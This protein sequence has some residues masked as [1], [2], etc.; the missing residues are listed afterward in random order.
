MRRT[1]TSENGAANAHPE[2]GLMQ[3][4]RFGDEEHVERVLKDLSTLGV[5]HLRTGISWADWYRPQG[6]AWYDWLL[7]RLAE[8]VNV[9]PCVTYTPPSLGVVPRS[10]APPRNPKL[11]AD[12]LDVLVTRSGDC[13]DTVELWNEPNNINNWDWRLDPDWAIFY[14]MIGGAAHWMKQRGKR[15]VLGGV[16]P[17]NFN[18]LRLLCEKKVLQNID[19]VGLCGLPGTWEHDTGGDWTAQIRSLHDRLKGLG[20]ERPLWITGTGYSTWRNDEH[21]QLLE[22]LK[23]VEAP[24][25]RVYW[26]S[27]DDLDPDW[28]FEEGFLQDERNYHFGL[29]RNDGTAKLLY[30]V[31]ASGGL[32]AIRSFAGLVN[33]VGRENSGHRRNSISPIRQRTRFRSVPSR[34]SSKPIV[35][36][37][38]AG[39]IGTNVAAKLAEDGHK[40]ILY[41][42]LSRPGVERN[43]RWLLDEFGE[44]IEVHVADVRD[45]YSLRRSVASAQ[46]IFHFAAQVAVTTSLVDPINDFTINGR[47]TLNVLE[48]CRSLKSPPPLLFTST[49]KVYGN[50]EDMRLLQDGERYVPASRLIRDNGVDESRPLDFHSPYGCS[51]GAADQY[52]L[53]YARCYELPNVVFRMSCIYGPHQCGTEDQGWVAHFVRQALKG[54]PITFYGDGRQVRDLLYVDDLVAAMMAAVDQIETTRGKAYNIGGGPENACSLREVVDLIGEMHEQDPQV[55]LAPWRQGDQ[56]YYVSDTRAFQQATGWKAAVNA[57]EGIE[58]LYRWLAKHEPALAAMLV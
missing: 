18:R 36:T 5:K 53:D 37:G 4:F 16:C 31:W 28:P 17:V 1:R 10:S 33:G 6:K 25:E 30:R 46:C 55:H 57:R 41:D 40:V 32:P 51:K 12:F 44:R 19:I 45:N 50:L 43:L 3:W 27:V 22:F 34:N 38:G 54:E 8:Q 24:V 20:Y 14:Q 29:K 23:L 9:L 11:Y 26:H 15:T 2:I 47:G 58:R 56:R 39:F 7:P 42:N 21:R 48:A 52:V 13:F 35:I 49:N